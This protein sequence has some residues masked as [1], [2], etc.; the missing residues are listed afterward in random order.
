MD[1][2]DPTAMSLPAVV[3]EIG[4][5]QGMM[6]DRASA[7]W[8]DESYQ[9]RL[10][11]L[12]EARDGKDLVDAESI[13]LGEYMTELAPV[14]LKEFGEVGPSMSYLDYVRACGQAA[15]VVLA[16]PEVERE[17]LIASFNWLPD[18]VAGAIA[19]ELTNRTGT[20]LGY[21]PDED[22]AT[23]AGY[24]GGRVVREWGSEAPVLMAR[25]RARLFRAMD[26]M[27]IVGEERF[28]DWLESLSDGQAAAVYRKLANG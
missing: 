7:Y 8:R 18:D 21:C 11:S 5:M 24:P 9:V 10:R 28:L 19:H 17:D 4:E 16:V 12:Y 13:D 20:G 23:F 25:V 27:T 6:G 3:A 1:R 2:P 22:V 26:S 15:D 14:S